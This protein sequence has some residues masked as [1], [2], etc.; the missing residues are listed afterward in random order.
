MA[1][2]SKANR[3]VQLKLRT[4]FFQGEGGSSN[5]ASKQIGMQKVAQSEKNSLAGYDSVVCQDQSMHGGIVSSIGN[6]V[7][8]Q[9]LHGPPTIDDV[10]DLSFLW[11]GVHG[12]Q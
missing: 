11:A 5:P 3:G 2:A 4:G 8:A 9:L 10:W 7:G 12:Q 1:S 6:S